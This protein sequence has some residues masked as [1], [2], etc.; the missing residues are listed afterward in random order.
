MSLSLVF[1]SFDLFSLHFYD[2]SCI[3]FRQY[4][5]DNK[6]INYPLK[7]AFPDEKKIVDRI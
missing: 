7:G 5:Y 2:N 1:I 3:V 6:Q 4:V